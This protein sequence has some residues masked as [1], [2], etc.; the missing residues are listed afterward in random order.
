MALL[1]PID[2]LC[3]DL[4]VLWMLTVT[5]QGTVPLLTGQDAVVRPRSTPQA[6][7]LAERGLHIPHQPTEW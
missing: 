5:V 2:S 1:V 7:V 6:V 4:R 3:P